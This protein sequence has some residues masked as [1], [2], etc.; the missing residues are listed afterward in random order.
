MRILAGIL[1]GFAAGWVATSV[2]VLTHG[3]M[4]RVSHAEGAFAMGAAFMAGPA[5]AV[6]GAVLGGVLAARWVGRER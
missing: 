5:G 4:A 6:L 3:E 1:L 2:A